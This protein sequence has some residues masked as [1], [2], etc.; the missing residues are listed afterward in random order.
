LL[1]KK[2][3]AKESRKELGS[4]KKNR[5]SSSSVKSP[6][7]SSA[8]PNRTRYLDSSSDDNNEVESPDE[9]SPR[10]STGSALKKYQYKNLDPNSKDAA[11]GKSHGNTCIRYALHDILVQT[12]V[13]P[14]YFFPYLSCTKP[15]GAMLNAFARKAINELQIPGFP[16]S[17]CNRPNR[18]ANL[19]YQHQLS[20]VDSQQRPFMYWANKPNTDCIERLFKYYEHSNVLAPFNSPAFIEKW[21]TV[22]KGI[23]NAEK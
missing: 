11:I 12:L 18:S 9:E 23:A 5:T 19:S 3:N 20:I 21:A 15:T 22:V 14:Y 4:Q 7:R 6:K 1:S 16:M 13:F 8:R 2:R 10:P 17:V